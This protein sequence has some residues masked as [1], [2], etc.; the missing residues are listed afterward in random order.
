MMPRKGFLANVFR[1]YS[2]GEDD[3]LYPCPAGEPLTAGEA[4]LIKG[5]FG[6]GIKTEHVRKYFSPK[7][8]PG[9]DEGYIIPAQTFGTDSIKFYSAR[10]KS[11]DY[12]QSKDLFNYGTFVHEMTHV[13]QNQH[14]LRRAFHNRLHPS[15]SYRY[16]L[17]PRSRF[18]N[19]SEEQ[20]ASIIGDYA[21]QFLYPDRSARTET[22]PS[23]LQKVVEDKFPQ[24]RKTRLALEAQ[25]KAILSAQRLQS[26][27]LC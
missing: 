3:A 5:I 7:A 20:Q 16:T 17:T 1:K 21:C 15:Y 18:R 23:L 8:K 22:S 13:W 10:Y 2:K 4:A 6:N 24:A 27:R 14:H 11:T 26:P 9:K 25:K 12:S 19:F